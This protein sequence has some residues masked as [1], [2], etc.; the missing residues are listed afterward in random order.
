M[1]TVRLEES[2]RPMG[3]VL[4][5]A[6]EARPGLQVRRQVAGAV[7][8]RCEP[9]WVRRTYGASC[10]VWLRD[11]DS[12]GLSGGR[13]S[14]NVRTHTRPDSLGSLRRDLEDD[15]AATAEAV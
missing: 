12:V 15:A 14:I 8:A 7:N 5:W 6:L 3:L 2:D 11:S 4:A 1:R 9:A 10:S 13:H